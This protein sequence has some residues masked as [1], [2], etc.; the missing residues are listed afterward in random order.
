MVN[1][2]ILLFVV[3]FLGLPVQVVASETERQQKS[4][5]GQLDKLGELLRSIRIIENIK[6]VVPDNAID[7]A[8]IDD[9]RSEFGIPIRVPIIS[10]HGGNEIAVFVFKSNRY[11]YVGESSHLLIDGDS[12]RYLTS[13][14][15]LYKVYL[16]FNGEP[17]EIDGNTYVGRS[18]KDMGSVLVNFTA[19]LSVKE[20]AIDSRT[21]LYLNGSKFIVKVKGLDQAKEVS[22]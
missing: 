20:V 2:L 14:Y 4:I 15:N 11:V 18:V 10:P 21:A 17:I 3:I 8:T 7:I 9:I 12:Y 16:L 6:T 22:K 13:T 5:I 19:G 1:F